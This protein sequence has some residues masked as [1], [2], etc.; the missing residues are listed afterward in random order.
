MSALNCLVKRWAEE[1]TLYNKAAIDNIDEP[2]EEFNINCAAGSI[3][4][5]HSTD[6]RIVALE[7]EKELE[8][9]RTKNKNLLFENDLIKSAYGKM[10]IKNNIGKTNE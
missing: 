5:L 10:V 6:L 9:L 3:C 1:S 7:I 4:F 2:T 8:E